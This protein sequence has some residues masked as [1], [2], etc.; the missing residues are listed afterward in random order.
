MSEFQGAATE[1]GVVQA[2]ALSGRG[3]ADGGARRWMSANG[4]EVRV[5]GLGDS[6]SAAVEDVEVGAGGGLVVRQWW[7]RLGRGRWAVPEL[8]GVEE[9]EEERQGH[10]R[11]SVGV[12]RG[13]RPTPG[14]HG[15]REEED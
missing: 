5:E 10:V 2:M 9:T 8:A 13:R 1:P 14:C 12:A 15:C 6:L 7:R 3:S 11:R 4:A